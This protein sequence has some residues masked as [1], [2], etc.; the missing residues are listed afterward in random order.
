VF[1]NLFT[2]WCTISEFV[3]SSNVNDG[4][5]DCCDGSDEWAKIRLPFRLEGWYF[6]T[7]GYLQC[8]FPL[9]VFYS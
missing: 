1:C 4:V 8:T 2:N 7:S 5:C 9:G 3:P 6:K